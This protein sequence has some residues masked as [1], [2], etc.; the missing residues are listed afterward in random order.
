MIKQTR[1]QNFRLA[2]PDRPLVEFHYLGWCMW[3][4]LKSFRGILK[5]EKWV[6]DMSSMHSG[7]FSMGAMGALAPLI[8]G[9]SITVTA[10]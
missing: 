9:Q 8:L 4:E 1:L 3:S 7:V 10:L 2:L 5:L 6:N